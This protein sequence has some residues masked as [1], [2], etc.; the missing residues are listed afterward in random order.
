MNV[1]VLRLADRARKLVWR[2]FGPRIVG[3]RAIVV[4]HGST[5]DES[6]PRVL[7]V[8]HSYGTRAWHLPGGGVKRR[9]S[10]EA[11]IRREVREEAGIEVTGTLRQ[12]GTYTNLQE[13][14]SDHVT[15]FV[16]EHWRRGDDGGHDDPEIAESGFFEVPDGLPEATSPGTRRRIEEWAKGHVSAFEW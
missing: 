8:H 13:G 15:V 6:P 7:L 5:G 4:D 14:K 3:V 12:L 16:I 2:A 11:G 1:I 9:E 10:L